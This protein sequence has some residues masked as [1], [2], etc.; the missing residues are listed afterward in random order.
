MKPV[1]C[2]RVTSFSYDDKKG[3]DVGFTCW[4]HLSNIIPDSIFHENMDRFFWGGWGG[5]GGLGVGVC[6]VILLFYS[7]WKRWNRF[8]YYSISERGE[9]LNYKGLRKRDLGRWD[10]LAFSEMWSLKHVRRFQTKSSIVKFLCLYV[11]C[12]F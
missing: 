7:G 1:S 5:V 12:C 9:I 8:C 10:W 6:R 11:V 4:C 3:S 2:D